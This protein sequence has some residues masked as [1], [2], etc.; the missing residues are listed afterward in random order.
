MGTI[1]AVIAS[2]VGIGGLVG[3]IIYYIRKSG[4]VDQ[5][6]DQANADLAAQKAAREQLEAAQKAARD[7]DTEEFNA[8]A[9]TITTA[10][11]AAE[12]LNEQF[13]TG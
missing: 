6:I 13:K 10:A 2:V 11:T 9:A 3:G 4:T 8:K 7:K 5:E 12:L 1:I